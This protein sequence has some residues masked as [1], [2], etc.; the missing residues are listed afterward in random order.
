MAQEQGGDLQEGEANLVSRLG[1]VEVDWPRTVGFY[2]G[3]AVAV[4]TELIAPPLALFIGA[5]PLLK[6]L[7]RPRAPRGVQ[8]VAQVLEGAAKPIGG[9]AEGTIRVTAEALPSRRSRR[10]ATA[11]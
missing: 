4:A 2:G 11:G 9:D 1:P 8:I 5:Y 10:P 7:N 3:L 6:M